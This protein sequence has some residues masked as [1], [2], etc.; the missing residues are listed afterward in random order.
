MREKYKDDETRLRLAL[1]LLVEGILCPTSGSTNISAEVVEMLA[2]LDGFLKYP[3]GRESFILTIRSVKGRSPA[4][5]A[6]DTIAIQGF[7]HAIV[8]VTVCCCPQIICE[9]PA[10]RVLLEEDVQIEDIVEEVCSRS[11][12]INVVTSRNLEVEGQATVTSILCP[13]HSIDGFRDEVTDVT[14]T[15]MVALINNKFPFEH[16]SWSGGV[17]AVDAKRLQEVGD[18][19]GLV[20]ENARGSN[21]QPDSFSPYHTAVPESHVGHSGSTGAPS[22]DV[23]ARVLQVVGSLK[24]HFDTVLSGVKNSLSEEI[25]QLKDMLLRYTKDDRSW[26]PHFSTEPEEDGQR[27]PPSRMEAIPETSPPPLRSTFG[28]HVD[29]GLASG[30]QP[31][32]NHMIMDQHNVGPS[33]PPLPFVATCSVQPAL[34]STVGGT[35]DGDVPAPP[36]APPLTALSKS[37]QSTSK[38]IQFGDQSASDDEDI[39][40][41][42][43]RRKMK[44]ST[45]GHI[46]SSTTVDVPSEHAGEA[47]NQI[48]THLEETGVS[49][50][51]AFRVAA[52][53]NVTATQFDCNG[54]EG[55]TISNVVFK[56]VFHGTRPLHF[57]AADMVVSFIRHRNLVEGSHRFEFLPSVFLRSLIREFRQAQNP[58][59]SSAFNF[60]TVSGVSLPSIRRWCVD[61]D[62]LYCPFQIDGQHWVGV[63]IDLKQWCI[64]VLDCN[65]ACVSETNVEN[66]LHPISV[67]FPELVKHYGGPHP[68]PGVL[69][70]CMPVER[71]DI[72][73]LCE[74]TG[75]SCVASVI[76]LEL[77]ATKKLHL[78]EHITEGCIRTAGERYAVE[79]FATFNP[80]LLAP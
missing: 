6:S 27:C 19:V 59:C 55:A 71:L 78:C 40:L 16:N 53:Q 49:L 54:G 61:I 21:F 60:T 36:Q 33:S 43:L 75:L 28:E 4:Q 67:I 23:E 14:V 69:T 74:I 35:G 66:A 32:R 37:F 50:F 3:W 77:H 31:G 57:E 48:L 73:L 76:L 64:H 20:D 1:L 13:N 12:K 8:L 2:D 45:T 51:V 11:L 10:D 22:E 29:G 25:K 58:G 63:S 17:K 68:R 46:L 44:V 52:F 80:Q 62:V 30:T 18:D 39:S 42:Q 24:S 41:A 7:A 5:Y 34:H 79:A 72:N 56:D 47:S 26:S 70:E 15:H 9:S 38:D 65:T